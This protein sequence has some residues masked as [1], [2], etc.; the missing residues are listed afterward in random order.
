MIKRFSKERNMKFSTK[1]NSFNEALNIYLDAS[2][3]ASKLNNILGMPIFHPQIDIFNNKIK[4]ESYFN[5][6]YH[7]HLFVNSK[8]LKYF[9]ND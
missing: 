8:N 5:F 3:K 4:I 6:K 9:E 2:K 1:Y 7:S